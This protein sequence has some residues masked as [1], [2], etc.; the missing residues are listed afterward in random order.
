MIVINLGSSVPIDGSKC[1]PKCS[2]LIVTSYTQHE[3]EDKF[4]SKLLSYLFKNDLSVYEKELKGLL[5]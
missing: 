3:M 2:G 5:Q 1:Y 4:Q